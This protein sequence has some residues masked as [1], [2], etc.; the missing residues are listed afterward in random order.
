VTTLADAPPIWNVANALTILRLVMVPA[1]AWT[2]AIG[3]PGLGWTAAALF[4]AAALTDHLDGHLARSRGLVTDFGKI[5]D[6]IADKALI[7]VTLIVLSWTRQLSWWVTGLILLREVG[8]TVLRFC[9]IRYRVIAASMGGKVKTVVQIIA[10]LLY[11]I[12]VPASWTW[13]Q[14]TAVVLMVVAVALTLATG[15]EYVYQVVV[16]LR[17][18]HS[19]EP[20]GAAA[21]EEGKN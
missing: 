7:G 19:K 10:I 20:G 18:A 2:L 17:A 11:V 8:I 6:P 3:T 16:L 4:A 14:W 9:V 12:P 13:L 5:A 15:A 21:G 1:V